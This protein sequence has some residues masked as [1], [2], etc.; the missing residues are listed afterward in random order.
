MPPPSTRPGRRGPRRSLAW[1]GLVAIAAVSC[2]DPS[3][4][5]DPERDRTAG[6]YAAIVEWFAAAH[7]DD[8]VPLPVFV[9]PRG[10]GASIPLEAQTALI[11]AT[12]D[13]ADVRFID[14]RDE[15]LVDVDGHLVAADDGLLLRLPPVDEMAR[16]VVADV[17][18]HLQDARFLTLRFEL[19]REG[20]QWS[21]TGPPEQLATPED[22]D[23]AERPDEDQDGG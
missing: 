5:P 10:D 16:P 2:T 17:D 7:D 22:T 21:V 3:S 13:E 11:T 23:P 14:V 15:A 18:V 8:P 20:E 6:V 4:T 19:D 12:A 1:A 9:E